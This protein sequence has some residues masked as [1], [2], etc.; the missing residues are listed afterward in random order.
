[1]ANFARYVRPRGF[2]SRITPLD[3]ISSTEAAGCHPRHSSERC[4]VTRDQSGQCVVHA[5]GWHVI[6]AALIALNAVG[7][8]PPVNH[9]DLFHIYSVNLSQG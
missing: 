3:S 2:P 4:I 1:V 5:R 7:A 9:G 8:A 6:V